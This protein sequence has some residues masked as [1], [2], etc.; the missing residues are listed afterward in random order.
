VRPYPAIHASDSLRRLISRPSAFQRDTLPSP[1]CS[2]DR[3]R[4]PP[5]T[6]FSWQTCTVSCIRDIALPRSLQPLFGLS[7]ISLA[8][9]QTPPN[10]PTRRSTSLHHHHCDTGCACPLLDTHTPSWT[11]LVYWQ[12]DSTTPHTLA[13]LLHHTPLYPIETRTRW[14]SGL[15]W[16]NQHQARAG[17][18]KRRQEAAL[19]GTTPSDHFR[20]NTTTAHHTHVSLDSIGFRTHFRDFHIHPSDRIHETSIRR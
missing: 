4:D 3:W 16:T 5:E 2:P 17:H 20:Y 15:D 8:R 14:N 10:Q 12:F 13:L 7:V 9:A 19:H 6:R 1:T 11:T 18:H